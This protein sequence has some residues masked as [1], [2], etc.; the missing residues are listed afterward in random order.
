[1]LSAYFRTGREMADGMKR[2]LHKPEEL[3]LD[4]EHPVKSGVRAHI[5]NPIVTGTGGRGQQILRAHCLI[6]IV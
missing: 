6:D 4:P 2:L 1:M 5:H 3:E